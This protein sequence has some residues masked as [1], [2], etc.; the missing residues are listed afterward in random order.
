MNR[1]SIFGIIF[2]SCVIASCQ[3]SLKTQDV[4]NTP[5]YKQVLA[6]NDSLKVSNRPGTSCWEGLGLLAL[7]KKNSNDKRS[8]F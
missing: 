7:G 1:T 2:I 6:E 5:E 3:Y 8:I 4:K